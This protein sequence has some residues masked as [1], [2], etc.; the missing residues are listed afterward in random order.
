MKV[1]NQYKLNVDLDT[2]MR[3]TMKVEFAKFIEECNGLVAPDSVNMGEFEDIAYFNSGALIFELPGVYWK[4]FDEVGAVVKPKEPK[5]RI[6][7]SPNTAAITMSNAQ[8]MKLQTPSLHVKELRVSPDLVLHDKLDTLCTEDVNTPSDREVFDHY[9]EMLGNEV[10]FLEGL[11]KDQIFDTVSKHL[12]LTKRKAAIDK[13]RRLIDDE[14]TAILD[15]K[16][17]LI[18]ST[19]KLRLVG[20]VS[21]EEGTFNEAMENI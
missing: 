17:E 12:V 3:K 19:D 11:S 6:A 4:Y 14:S 15:A 20:S 9:I 16:S 10:T 2:F 13:L 8:S 21:D 18:E 7:A 1:G 5:N